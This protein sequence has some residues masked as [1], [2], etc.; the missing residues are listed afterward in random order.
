EVRNLL[1]RRHLGARH[2]LD[3]REPAQPSIDRSN[4]LDARDDGVEIVSRRVVPLLEIAEE[5]VGRIAR[6]GAAQANL[7]RGVVGVRLENGPGQVVL[8]DRVAGKSRIVAAECARQAEDVEIGIDPAAPRAPHDADDDAVRRI[9]T[10]A[11]S[12]PRVEAGIGRIAFGHRRVQLAAAQELELGVEL[13]DHAHL[14]TILKVEADTVPFDENRD[15]VLFE[16][17]SRT[18][19]GQHEKL[20]AVERARGKTDLAAGAHRPE[21]R[22]ESGPGGPWPGS[23]WVRSVSVVL[24]QVFDADC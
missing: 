23:I 22:R 10:G 7:P 9:G 15:A 5:D 2:T 3:R 6:I 11:L 8:L 19:P 13:A 21:D 17:R 14:V 24:Q 4:E 12:L 20:R 1:R 16:V 18:Y